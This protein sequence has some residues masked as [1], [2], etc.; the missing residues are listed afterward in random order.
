MKVGQFH[1]LEGTAELPVSGPSDLLLG[2]QYNVRCFEAVYKVRGICQ[3]AHI[4][5]DIVEL[6]DILRHLDESHFEEP[7]AQ[8]HFA[9]GDIR[10]TADRLGIGDHP[11][12]EVVGCRK[13]VRLY[14]E[15]VS[16]DVAQVHHSLQDICHVSQHIFEVLRRLVRGLCK[17]TE[18]RHVSKIIVFIEP[19][20][21]AQ[22]CPALDDYFGGFFHVRGN[23]KASGEVVCRP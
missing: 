12:D 21:V 23:S 13:F 10:K 9:S 3:A 14:P 11:E 17:K 6:Q 19:A 2:L 5:H 7:V 20:K 22:K 15:V 8:I 18:G 1:P 16:P 4:L